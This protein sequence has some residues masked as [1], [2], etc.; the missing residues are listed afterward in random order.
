MAFLYEQM[1]DTIKSTNDV[2]GKLGVRLLGIF[3]LIKSGMF[4]GTRT[5]PLNPTEI[6]DPKGTVCRIC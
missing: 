4:K 6:V 1:D 5:L 3:P 2:E